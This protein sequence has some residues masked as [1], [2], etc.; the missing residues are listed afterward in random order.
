MGAGASANEEHAA[1]FTTEAIRLCDAALLRQLIRLDLP[2]HV[3]IRK[4]HGK[5]VGR[6]H[7]ETPAVVRTQYIPDAFVSGSMKKKRNQHHVV[8]D[9]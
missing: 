4:Q 1:V 6:W 3:F 2:V 8:R 5:K 9:R 7:P